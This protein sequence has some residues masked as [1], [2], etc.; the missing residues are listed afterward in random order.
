MRL[1]RDTR[2]TCQQWWRR[3]SFSR[4]N[5]APRSAD[6]GPRSLSEALRAS[7]ASVAVLCLKH[8]QLG[9]LAGAAHPLNNNAG[10]L[11][12]T[13]FRRKRILE[14]KNKCYFDFDFQY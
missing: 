11:R 4:E 10:V 9:S 7:V 12:I 2:R 8:F 1:E 14:Y 5:A 3:S 6:A 13:P